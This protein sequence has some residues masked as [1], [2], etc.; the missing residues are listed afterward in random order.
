MPY[1]N[2]DGEIFYRRNVSESIYSSYVKYDRLDR[3]VYDTY[4]NC[5][6]QYATELN[7]FIDL[8][9]ML[10]QLFSDKDRTII[11]NYTDVSAA[12][13]NMCAHYRHFFYNNLRVKTKFF[14]IFSFNINE[15]NRKFMANYNDEYFHK[16]TDVDKYKDIVY[17]NF[18]LLEKLC[19]YIPDIFFIKSEKNF[20]VS[21]IISHIID[22]LHDG[23]PN[24][25][26]SKESCPIQLCAL[27]PYTSFL[28]PIKRRDEYGNTIDQSI[29]IPINEKYNYREEFWKFVAEDLG[30]QAKYFSNLNPLNYSLLISMYKYPKRNYK[31]ATIDIIN[32]SKIITELGG[33]NVQVL[34]QMLY[35][36]ETAIKYPLAKVESIYNTLDVP[37]MRQYYDIDPE[38]KS[39]QFVN[40]RDDSMLNKI[41]SKF[42]AEN[43]ID[44][45][46]LG[47]GT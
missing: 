8:G 18:A 19:Q 9:S 34:P 31:V 35:N 39:L 40:M 24:L 1:F 21:V 47:E 12:V 29:M 45:F 26:I 13:I 7:I 46:K 25:I 20:E 16:V 5:S 42:F 6:I 17:N 32:A 2:K 23:L 36:S 3:I 41:C 37:F 44:L 4:S 30:V 22:R 43:P 27:H 38:C 33:E 14:L 10:H 11:E 28:R 15:I